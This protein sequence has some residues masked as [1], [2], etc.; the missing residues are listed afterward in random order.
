MLTALYFNDSCY[1]MHICI[2]RQEPTWATPTTHRDS[3]LTGEMN[4]PYSLVP[5][6][7][8][9]RTALRAAIVPKHRKISVIY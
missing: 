7:A 9:R 2:Q 3:L 4:P 8:T 5:H 1:I 6:A